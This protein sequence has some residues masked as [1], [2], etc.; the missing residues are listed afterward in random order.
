MNYILLKA[1]RLKVRL[2]WTLMIFEVI[3]IS[4]NGDTRPSAITMSTT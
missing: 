1:D 4:S 2:S 3:L